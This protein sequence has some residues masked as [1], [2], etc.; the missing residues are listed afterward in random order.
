VHGIGALS[1]LAYVSTVDDPARFTRSR[2]V[3]H[4][5]GLHRDNISRAIALTA[6]RRNG[7]VAA[8]GG[9]VA[10]HPSDESR[11]IPHLG[12]DKPALGFPQFFSGTVSSILVRGG[13][14]C[15]DPIDTAR[16]IHKVTAVLHSAPP[17]AF[18]GAFPAR[19]FEPW[20]DGVSRMNGRISHR[21]PDVRRRAG[22]RASNHCCL[23]AIL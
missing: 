14:V 23:L 15:D 16:R 22:R 10:I 21:L 2:S 12:S 6:T 20:R 17:D 7:R 11:M 18:K 13:L 5:W 1:V 19:E 3:G 4:I 8:L 9:L